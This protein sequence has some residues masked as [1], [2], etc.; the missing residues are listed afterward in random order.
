MSIREKIY[1]QKSKRVNIEAL[2][3]A[4]IEKSS[5]ALKGETWSTPKL[6]KYKD[7]NFGSLHTGEGCIKIKKDFKPCWNY[8][9]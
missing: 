1:H 8:S 3:K 9:I 2:E 5:R 6:E 4:E 7:F